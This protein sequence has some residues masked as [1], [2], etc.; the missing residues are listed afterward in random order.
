MVYLENAQ[1]CGAYVY[2]KQYLI[3]CTYIALYNHPYLFSADTNETDQEPRRSNI[4]EATEYKGFS[5][6]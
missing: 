3:K 2:E 6:Q 5:F 4:I 1:G